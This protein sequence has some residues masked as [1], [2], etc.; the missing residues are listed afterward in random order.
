MVGF[1]GLIRLLHFRVR[2]NV[3][4]TLETYSCTIS[5]LWIDYHSFVDERESSSVMIEMTHTES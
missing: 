5:L 4:V 2:L 1:T 3:L